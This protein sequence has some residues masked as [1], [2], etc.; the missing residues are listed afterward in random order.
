MDLC[1]IRVILT[2]GSQ[3][4]QSVLVGVIEDSSHFSVPLLIEWFGD[5]R[6]SKYS[7][8][9]GQV[10]SFRCISFEVK[11]IL[12]SIGLVFSQLSFWK[13]TGKYTIDAAAQSFAL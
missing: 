10:I 13:Q 2:L 8:L 9:Y 5:S 3:L 11:S 7:L 1:P 12:G 4:V 6:I